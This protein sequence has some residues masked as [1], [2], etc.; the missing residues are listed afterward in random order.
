MTK[1]PSFQLD[2]DD[3][4][5]WLLYYSLRDVFD[6]ADPANPK[7]SFKAMLHVL[8]NRNVEDLDA[9]LDSPYRHRTA[10]LDEPAEEPPILGC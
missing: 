7:A 4:S 2:A 3:P 8:E 6:H 5:S 10:Y 1:N 9:H